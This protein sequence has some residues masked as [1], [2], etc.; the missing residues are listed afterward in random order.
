MHRQSQYIYVTSAT[1][2]RSSTENIIQFT[3]IEHNHSN[4]Y[5]QTYVR[6]ENCTSTEH[7]YQKHTKWIRNYSYP[8]PYMQRDPTTI[9]IITTY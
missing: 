8:P 4:R 1:Y 3:Y 5:C 7:L 9:I 6:T 2:I